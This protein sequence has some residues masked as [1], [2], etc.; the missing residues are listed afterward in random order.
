MRFH[1]RRLGRKRGLSGKAFVS[2][3]SPIDNSS[4]GSLRIMAAS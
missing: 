3:D 2:A 1:S 4:V